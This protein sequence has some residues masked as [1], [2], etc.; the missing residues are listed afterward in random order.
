MY[1]NVFGY[2]NIYSYISIVNTTHIYAISK[3]DTN[4]H[5]YD[6][7]IGFFFFFL[8]FWTVLVSHSVLKNMV[9]RSQ[10]QIRWAHKKSTRN[11]V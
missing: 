9:M 1:S 11:E 4:I 6:R 5:I 7:I 2:L 8:N 3:A 10:T